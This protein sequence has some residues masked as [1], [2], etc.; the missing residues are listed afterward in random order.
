MAAT[1]NSPT[2]LLV[3][4][5]TVTDAATTDY[6]F[7]VTR[8]INILDAAITKGPIN[9]A[10]VNTVQL[11]TGAAAAISNAMDGNVVASTLVRATVIDDSTSRIAALGTL[12]IR[13][14]KGGGDAAY[15]VNTYC[16]PA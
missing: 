3:L 7:V 9:A 11:Q 5:T 2:Q 15:D 4:R 1:F 14:V 6:N 12:R 13:V 16:I 8:G 10:A